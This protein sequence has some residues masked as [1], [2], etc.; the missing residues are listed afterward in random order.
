[1]I[2]ILKF[3]CLRGLR[4]STKKKSLLHHTAVANSSPFENNYFT[5]VCSGSEAGSYL[6]LIDLC[7]TRL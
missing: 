4:V 5:E 7:I 3:P 6:R 1:M 2:T